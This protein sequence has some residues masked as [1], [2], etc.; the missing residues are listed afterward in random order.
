[1]IYLVY[2]NPT[3]DKTIYFDSFN[4]GKTNRPTK[5]IED[6][7]G[8]A[9]NAAVVLSELGAKSCCIGFVFDKDADI[10]TDRLEK[11]G[12]EYDFITLKGSSRINTKIFDGKKSEIT[13][14]N[15]SGMEISKEDLDKVF[16]KTVSKCEK[17]D[18]C[19]MTGS[20]PKGC[21]KNM[22]AKMIKALKEKGVLTVLDAD[23]EVLELA[24]KEKP[25]FTKPNVDEIKAI[26]TLESEDIKSVADCAKKLA[27]D[28]AEIIGISMGGDGAIISDGIDA[29]YAPPLKLN[30]L[31]TV[32]AGDSM[33]A[34]IVY[35]IYKGYGV[36]SALKYGVACASC[37]VTKEGTKLAD[38]E[39]IKE[40]LDIVEVKKV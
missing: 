19:I 39:G 30:V 34:G 35:S 15:E 23:G 18:I 16:E 5:I 22:Y 24:I 29:F 2:L 36:D 12:V 14:I 10:I 3:I 40:F 1:M 33:V 38:K 6:G 37:S 8:K 20:L 11:Y 21:E 28:K 32:G 4:I 31:S 26:A 25:Y 9:I 27:G 13:E 7:A 17:G